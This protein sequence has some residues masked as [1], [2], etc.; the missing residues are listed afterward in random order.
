MLKRQV[1]AAIMHWPEPD[2]GLWE[3]RGPARHFTSS[4]IMCWVAANRGAKFAGLRGEAGL[5]ASWRKVALFQHQPAARGQ[6][7]LVNR[8]DRRREDR[9]R[10]CQVDGGRVRPG[11]AARH[12]RGV[13]QV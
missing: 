8:G 13:G 7:G 11:H 6:P 2:Q 5:A 1:E 4:K 9:R 10:K 12:A 3:V